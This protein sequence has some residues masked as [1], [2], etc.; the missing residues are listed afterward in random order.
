MKKKNMIALAGVAALAVV[1]GTLAFYNSTL[2]VTNKLSTKGYESQLIEKFTPKDDWQPGV[3]V[4][5]V[6]QVKNTGDYPVLARVTYTEVWKDED[7]KEKSSGSA[8]VDYADKQETTKVQK[9]LNTEDWIYGNDGYYYYKDL[10]EAKTGVSEAFLSNITMKSDIDINGTVEKT[11]YYSTK[12][13]DSAEE[14]KAE[15]WSILAEGSELPEGTTFTRVVEKSGKDG[16]ANSQ[17][18]LVITAQMLQSTK[19]AVDNT[20][21]PSWKDGLTA[22]GLYNTFFPAE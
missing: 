4:D 1:G 7:G 2:A 18:E 20:G 12:K 9:T 22:A 10:I 19:E 17:Y 6:V 21:D 3:T 5:K 14:L 11:T 13:V 8:A 15:D 16:Y